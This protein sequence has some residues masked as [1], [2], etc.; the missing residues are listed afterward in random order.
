M[1]DQDTDDCLSAYRIYMESVDEYDAAMA[2]VGSMVRWRKLLQCKWFIE[3]SAEQSFS[4][5]KEWRTDMEMRDSSRAKRLAAQHLAEG[6]LKA[7]SLML[8]IAAG[9]KTRQPPTPKHK[10]TTGSR[11][12]TQNPAS[13]ID[14]AAQAARIKPE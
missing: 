6:D 9:K 1:K 11:R 2:L 13:V 4:G 10:P 12:G 14:I 7:A 8:D 3:G 5:L